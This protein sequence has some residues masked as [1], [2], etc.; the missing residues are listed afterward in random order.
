LNARRELK[1]TQDEFREDLSI[2]R[3]E[4]LSK[5]QLQITEAIR[6]LGRDQRYDVILTD[7][8]V[9]FSS[10]QVDLTDDVLSRLKK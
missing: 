8:N 9:I 5:L 1:R 3:N 10:K 6:A 2:R 7:A 4:E